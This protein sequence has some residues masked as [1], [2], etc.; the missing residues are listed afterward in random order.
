MCLYLVTKK[1]IIELEPL[2]FQKIWPYKIV[3]SK[4]VFKK[5]FFSQKNKLYYL[6]KRLDLQP[7]LV[8]IVN[9][10][11]QRNGDR[12]QLKSWSNLISKILNTS[13]VLHKYAVLSVKLYS[14]NCSFFHCFIMA[15]F[16]FKI[17]RS[18]S[19]IL[20]TLAVELLRMCFKI[21]NNRIFS[22]FSSLSELKLWGQNLKKE[23]WPCTWNQ[24]ANLR[25]LE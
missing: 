15:F 23:R 14:T 20:L 10:L 24:R 8:D 4:T 2:E 12:Y 19:R 3:Q 11:Q 7:M 18:D 17:K 1:V 22:S 9:G 13:C 25:N 21:I 5:V 16:I 6:I